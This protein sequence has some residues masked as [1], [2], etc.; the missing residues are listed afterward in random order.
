MHDFFHSLMKRG[1]EVYLS[2]KAWFFQ[3]DADAYSEATEVIVP[4]LATF[5]SSSDNLVDRMQSEE[6][7]A[8]TLF[9]CLEVEES[10]NDYFVPDE[11]FESRTSFGS[12]SPS[13]TEMTS[14][15]LEE[16]RKKLRALHKAQAKARK[17][18]KKGCREA[19]ISA[20]VRL[21][22]PVTGALDTVDALTEETTRLMVLRELKA[23]NVCDRDVEWLTMYSMAR[24]LVPNQ[25]DLDTAGIINS[26][27]AVKRRDM[28]TMLRSSRLWRTFYWK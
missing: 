21:V 11:I 7:P 22:K 1:R 20:V 25:I 6:E 13:E 27:E 24:I 15:Q 5:E 26:Q 17:H 19:A 14:E 18:V 8:L 2:F 9:D 16:N 10:T 28:I 4:A 23:M 12:T 3:Q